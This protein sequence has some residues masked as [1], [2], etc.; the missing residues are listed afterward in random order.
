[1]YVKEALTMSNK[2]DFTVKR[3]KCKRMALQTT[4]FI[5]KTS[6]NQVVLYNFEMNCEKWFKLSTIVCN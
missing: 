1:M 6:A 3:G 2:T 5:Y 4:V